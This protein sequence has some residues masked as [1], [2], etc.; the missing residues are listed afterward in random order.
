ME[1]LAA[2]VLPE[3]MSSEWTGASLEQ[4]ESGGQTVLIFGLGVLFV[5]WCSRPSTRASLAAGGDL[6]VPLAI[7]GAL[8][9]QAR[10][11]IPRRVLSDRLVCWSVC[12]ARTRSSSWSSRGS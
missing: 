7:L 6:S 5:F 4:K 2:E 11:A 1:Q 10:A 8:A 3:G 9:L 12:R